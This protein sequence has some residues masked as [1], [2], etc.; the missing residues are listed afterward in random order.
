M[1][2]KLF[3]DSGWKRWVA[4]N[5]LRG[6]PPQELTRILVENGFPEDH[7]SLEVETAINHPY[8]AAGLSVVRQLSKR[9]W[10]LHTNRLL[11]ESAPSQLTEIWD[12]IDAKDFLQRHYRVNRPLVIRGGCN[13]MAAMTKWTPKYLKQIAGD[14]EVQI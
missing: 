3:L 11:L 8:V 7:A 6:R 10:V 4:E 2:E 1:A 9:D 13:S 14:R 12:S 5:A